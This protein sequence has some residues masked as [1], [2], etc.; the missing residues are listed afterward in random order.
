MQLMMAV[1]VVFVFYVFISNPDTIFLSCKS[2]HE[3]DKMVDM[4][5]IL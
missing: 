2:M 1:S 4:F 5:Q 3:D